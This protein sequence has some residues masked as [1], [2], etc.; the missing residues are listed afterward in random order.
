MLHDEHVTNAG[1]LPE[2]I[3]KAAQERIVAGIYQTLVFGVVNGDSSE[4]VAFGKLDDGMVTPPARISRCQMDFGHPV[5]SRPRGS[6]CA[7]RN[8]CT[9]SRSEG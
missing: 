9:A 8:A 7:A 1:L 5:P 6:G 2:R 3:E 4:V